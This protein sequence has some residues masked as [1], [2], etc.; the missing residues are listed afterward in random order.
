[1]PTDF[2]MKRA[3]IALLTLITVFVL[4]GHTLAQTYVVDGE[5]ITEWLV[6][7]SFFP[8]DLGT[9][10]LADAGGES[11]IES[12][13]GDTVTT[14]DGIPLTWKRYKS[15]V[16]IIDLLEAVGNYEN[17]TAYAFCEMLCEAEGDAEIYI[18]SDDGVAVW[19]N[20][21]QV[22]INPVNRP[23]TLDSDVFEVN[24]KAGVNRCLVKVS[25]GIGKWGFAVRVLPPN[26]AVIS[27]I[28]TDPAGQP[29]P[30][31]YVHLEQDGEEIAQ[32]KTDASGRY[33][34][35]IYPVHGQYDIAA[36]N[37]EK[38]DWRLGI[39]L[40]EGE[41][42]RLNL[43]LK[44]AISIEGT[45]LMLD[46]ST[47]HVA[48]PVQ[49]IRNGKVIAGTL[50]DEG[51]K[52]RLVNLKAGRYQL[53]CQILGGYVYYEEG[54]KAVVEP[55]NAAFLKV[56]RSKT[57][58]DI[59]FHFP[60]FKKGTWRHYTVIDGLAS[61]F[62]HDIHQDSDGML[63]FA[64]C[65]TD[66]SKG[67]GVSRYDGKE[68]VVFTT[69]DGLVGNDVFSIHSAPD[70]VMWFGTVRGGVS[71]YDGKEFVNFTTKDGLASN[72]VWCINGDPDG[73]IWFGT[74]GG[75]VSRYDG[76]Q[77]ENFTIEDGLAN[78][79]LLGMHSDANGVM[80]F[81]TDGGGV[82]RYDG[83]EFVNLTTKDGLVSDAPIVIHRDANGIMWFGTG[84]PGGGVSRYDGKEFKNFTQKDG[85]SHNRVW[86][87]HI[88]SDGVM[89]FATDNGVSRYD[90]KTF[91]NF[92][93]ADG[94]LDDW[95]EAI[96][97][98]PDGV[99]WFGTGLGGV[100]RYDEKS[101]VSLTTKD[102]LPSNIVADIHHDA[103]GFLWAGT[104]GGLAR[105]KG[106][107]IG[108][109]AP[110][111]FGPEDGFTPSFV[112]VIHRAPDGTLWVATSGSGVFRYDSGSGDDSSPS[113]VNF[114]T[115]DGLAHNDVRAICSTPDGVMW[116]GTHG[117]GVSR[118]DGNGFINL[119]T[120]DGL[121]DDSVFTIHRDLDDRMWFGTGGGVSRYDGEEFINLTTE[122][123]LVDNTVFRI[124]GAPDGVMWFGTLGGGV[125]R[126]DGKEFINFT[127]EDGLVS[128]SI[129][130]IY[131]DPD[132][133]MWFGTFG[134]GVSGYDG[135]AWT[136]LD[137]R[138]G[139]ADNRV[140][141]IEP[142]TDGGLWFATWDGLT[143]YRRSKTPPRVYIVSVT[144]DQTY[145][146]LDSIPAFT[147]GTRVT[148]EYNAIDFNT[149][150]EKR[151]YR[152]RIQEVDSD[153]RRPT[154][155]SFFDYTFKKNGT[156][157]FEVQA[158]DR[159]LNYSQPASVTL[160]VV[161]P[162]YLNGWIAFPSGGFIFALLISFIFFGLRYYAQRKSVRAYERAA[163]Q[164]LRDAHDMQISLMPESAPLIEGIEITG[165]CVPANTVGGDFFDYLSLAN[166]RIGIAL[167]DIS[168]KG[169]KG[170]MNAVL[171]N[172]MLDEVAKIEA[173]CGKILSALNAGLY[174]RMEKMMFAAFGFAILEQDSGNLLWAN[175]AQ[176]YPIVKRDR[177]VFEFKSEGGLPLGMMPRVEYA[178]SA[179]EL[180]AGDLV[181]FY[182]DG[183]IE[184]EN[185]TDEMYGTERL[186]QLITR[187]NSTMN[188]EEI[189]E[190]IL[191]DVADFVGGAEQYD[192]MTVVV[193]KKL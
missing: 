59:D 76:N 52:Y 185:K 187:I 119:T 53:Q 39:R 69:E 29:I 143:R 67:S 172:G 36:T 85:L 115:F 107:G 174:P 58:K 101:F 61:M 147:L 41:H 57:L 151:Q 135:I 7:G 129:S 142:D 31:A 88:D 100:S 136:L 5:Y 33:R 105:Y 124:H 156:Y 32:T 163:V 104:A 182:T 141:S 64:S 131:R 12:K 150:P 127:K 46:D 77:F 190:T 157:T 146:D 140:Y 81:G 103:G 86:D 117:G 186:E 91:V 96:H 128:N 80:W 180:Q 73:V 22:H 114:T 112:R 87:I 65:S 75:G 28:I 111:T 30:Q 20:G 166:G 38:G 56:E 183:L 2:T 125:S 10:F 154:K 84:Y 45:L 16:A 13:E 21:G 121:A 177:Q 178:D 78:N 42:Q 149:I 130:A 110:I 191:Q 18:G 126:Y 97:R 113:F 179:L 27:G 83:K 148:I 98:T 37:G 193:V 92:T 50:S 161:P 49:A 95:V 40:Y 159:D 158:I 9:D 184:A 155:A 162:W 70:G 144:T 164:E 1:M 168:G 118:Y 63:W 82:S 171:T 90:G 153:W 72:Y 176:P 26:R 23:L 109:R 66:T 93:T 188:G 47:P 79:F 106:N 6:L 133:I 139:L 25:N 116:F 44:E 102:G 160:K 192:D 48:V 138:D 152:Y 122:D 123:G 68:F 54:E 11:N 169:L 71:R 137:T 134:G 8:D 132:G 120:K 173:S 108:Y 145:R 89:W 43:T 35:S 181:I 94:L 14:V 17:A 4:T 15:K 99:M 3:F 51:G 167:A 62:V 19:I 165:K 175:A 170:A 60:H 74:Y 24:L 55:L 189:I 34:L